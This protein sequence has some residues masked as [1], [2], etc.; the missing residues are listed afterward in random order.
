MFALLLPFLII[1]LVIIPYL[2]YKKVLK[3]KK[4]KNLDSL[5]ALINFG[6]FYQEYKH[7]ACYWELVKIY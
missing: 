6:Y 4:N 2:I 1:F 5:I 7:N 3:L